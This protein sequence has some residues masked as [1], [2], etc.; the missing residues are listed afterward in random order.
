MKYLLTEKEYINLK[1]KSDNFE[2][3]LVIIDRISVMPNPSY[4]QRLNYY[5]GLAEDLKLKTNRT[6]ESVLNELLSKKFIK[7]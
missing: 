1:N 4:L 7:T 6:M 2:K 3:L 5:D